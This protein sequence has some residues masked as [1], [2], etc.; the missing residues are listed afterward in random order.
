MLTTEINAAVSILRQNAQR[1][2][3]HRPS[4]R[5][6]SREFQPVIDRLCA[7]ETEPFRRALIQDALKSHLCDLVRTYEAKSHGPL[8]PYLTRHL[9]AFHANSL[10]G[11]RT[12]LITAIADLPTRQKEVFQ[13]RYFECFSLSEIACRMRIQPKSVQSLLRRATAHLRRRL[14]E[15]SL[16]SQ[17]VSAL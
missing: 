6:I 10:K 17:R 14:A 5:S 4:T 2:P 12:A 16:D 7:S 15:L 13:H 3:H 11:D 8:R 1:E 9:Y